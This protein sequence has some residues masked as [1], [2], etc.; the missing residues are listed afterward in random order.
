MSAGSLSIENY[1]ARRVFPGRAAFF[2][3]FLFLFSLVKLVW[4]QTY[5]YRSEPFSYDSP[6]PTAGTVSWHASSASPACTTYPQGDDDWADVAF[7]TG[8]TF[9]FAGSVYTSVRVY[10]NGIL[11][12]GDDASGFHRTFTPTALP[13]AVPG[14]YSGCPRGQPQRVMLPYWTD[15]VAGTANSTSGASVRFEL[16]GSAPDRRFVISFVNVKLYNQ[17]ARYNFQTVLWEGDG[18]GDDEFS[19]RYSSGSST[20]TG[21]TVGV[22]VSSTDFTQYAFNQGFVDTIN[23]TSIRW[24]PIA[25]SP[26]QVAEY[27]LDEAGGWGAAPTPQEIIVDSSGEGN[28]GRRVALASAFP[29]A[30]QPGRIC[31][32]ATIPNNTLADFISALDLGLSPSQIGKAGTITFWYRSADAW[33][34]GRTLFDASTLS[35]RSFHLTRIQSGSGALL[36]FVMTDSAGTRVLLNSSVQT[37]AANT[38]VHVGVSWFLQPG[39]NQT[40]MQLFVNG[41]RVGFSRSTTTGVLHNSIASIYFGDNRTSGVTPSDGTPTSANGSLDEIRVYNFDASEGQVDRDRRLTRSNCSPLDH[42]SIEHAGAGSV[43]QATRISIGAHDVNHNSVPLVGSVMTLSASS[44]DGSWVLAGATG[45]LTNLGGGAARYVWNNES[46]ANFTFRSAR[47]GSV[48]FDVVSGGISERSGSGGGAHDP[49]LVLGSCVDKFAAC[50]STSPRC[51]PGTLRF[52]RL[53]TKLSGSGFIFDAVALDASGGLESGFSGAVSLHLLANLQSGT[54]LGANAC[55]SSSSQ[56]IDAGTLSFVNGRALS[57]TISIAG[58]YQDVRARFSCSSAVCGQEI[59]VCSPD[60]FAVR[61]QA[62]N[63]SGVLAGG[64]LAAGRGFVLRAD[65]GVG[66][67]YLGLPLIDLSKLVDHANNSSSALSGGFVANSAGVASGQFSYDDVG[68]FKLLTDAVTDAGFAAE[69]AALGDCV[70]NSTAN[71]ASGGKIGCLIGSAE[72]GL[73]GRFH[74]DHFVFN[75]TLSPACGGFV[76]MEQPQMG[77][78]IVLEARNAKSAVTPRYTAGYSHLGTPSITGEN[79]GQNV[80]LSRLRPALTTPAWTFG[81]YVHSQPA[82]IF[83][84]ASSP[85]GPFESFRLRAAVLAEPDGVGIQ[86]AVLSNPIAVRHGRLRLLNR[87]GSE[88][89]DLE[90]PVKADFWTGKSWVPSVNDS[91][92]TLPAASFFLSGDLAGNTTVSAVNL[93]NGLGT[94]RLSKPNPVATGS[95]DIAVNLGSSGVDQS[96]LATHGGTPAGVPWLRSRNGSCS[97][98]Y[99]RDPSARASFGIYS[100]ESRKTVHV[101]ELF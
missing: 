87:I 14:S 49:S 13:A 18:S 93:T 69:D 31:V 81:R 7:P 6:S 42:F 48:N 25:V 44:G 23:G 65:S 54:T 5:A 12:F 32:G 2:V 28:P 22:Q 97:T 90:L 74:P 40:V 55:P 88:K 61:P 50:E 58:A 53:F 43:C 89:S 19:F 66:T 9:R 56:V 80:S 101:R 63:L 70:V 20:G 73:I 37:F 62:F 99:D 39:T 47:T 38:W 17:T 1:V 75:A 91:C 77:V 27:R 4:A 15:I 98:G 33:T 84:R 41:V 83:S 100:P 51:Q 16:L 29:S 67:T 3:L 92:T 94:L 34:S 68:S 85:D 79:A 52:D 24:Y 30:A 59:V 21:A 60:N 11:A 57:S 76:Y 8:F 95:V 96:C 26:A 10:S 35:N 64:K 36:R 46:V 82:T 78:D 71:A 45:S 86:G 72:S